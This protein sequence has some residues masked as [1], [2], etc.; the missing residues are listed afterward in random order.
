[1]AP[2]SADVWRHKLASTD[3][4][5]ASSEQKDIESFSEGSP[6]TTE[7]VGKKRR[8]PHTSEGSRKRQKRASVESHTVSVTRLSVPIC[9]ESSTST[10]QEQS[11]DSITLSD[12]EANPPQAVESLPPI[13]EEPLNKRPR[14]LRVSLSLPE[15]VESESPIG[16]VVKASHKFKTPEFTPPTTLPTWEEIATVTVQ[17][18]ISLVTLT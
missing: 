14:S 17:P 2:P 10:D 1:M 4:S 7:I 3:R 12:T 6:S 15:E 5:Q 11:Y 18:K 9:E 13:V 8:K 16:K